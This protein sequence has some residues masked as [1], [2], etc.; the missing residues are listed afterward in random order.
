MQSCTNTTYVSTMCCIFKL[1]AVCVNYL[2]VLVP[3]GHRRQPLH[4]WPTWLEPEPVRWGPGLR[5]MEE[6]VDGAK[7]NVC[8]W[9]FKS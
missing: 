4:S 2:L 8:F 6:A 7:T 1:A 3:L 9:N 5:C